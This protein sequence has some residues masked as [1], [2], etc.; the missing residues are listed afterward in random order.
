MQTVRLVL[1][2]VLYVVVFAAGMILSRGVALHF[3][4]ASAGMP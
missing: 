2:S 4:G 3:V 1:L